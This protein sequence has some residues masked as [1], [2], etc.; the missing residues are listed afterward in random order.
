MTGM[1]PFPFEVKLWLAYYADG[2]SFVVF[3]NELEALRYAV[4][5]TMQVVPLEL[6]KPLREH[7][8]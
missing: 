6:G 7:I 4:A 8:T 3:D 1:P 5:N 2:S